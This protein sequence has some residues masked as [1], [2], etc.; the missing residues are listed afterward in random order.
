MKETLCFPEIYNG[1]LVRN[2]LGQMKDA[3]TT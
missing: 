2:G 3:K 1:C